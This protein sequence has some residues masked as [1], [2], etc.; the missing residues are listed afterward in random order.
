MKGSTLWIVIIFGLP[1]LP[2]AQ[3]DYYS[4]E[5]II[6]F[7]DYLFSQTDYERAI[8][9]YLR[10]VSLSDDQFFRDSMYYRIAAGF[11]YLSKPA[12]ARAYCALI[13]K[14]PAQPGLK[15]AVVCLTAYS[16]YLQGNNDS[17]LSFL[18]AAE[19]LRMEPEWQH[20]LDAIKIA[21]FL[22]EYQWT[23]ATM[24][25]EK[26][27]E[28]PFEKSCND[29]SI[30]ELLEIG[31][32]GKLLQ[33]KNP[34]FAGIASAAIPGSGKVY[35][36]RGWDGL[37][38][39]LII[40]TMLWQAY[41]G[42]SKEGYRSARGITFGTLGLTFYAGNIYGSVNAARRYNQSRESAIAQRARCVFT[43]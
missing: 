20:R 42:F 41:E 23:E 9:E 30:H 28:K 12:Q 6:R 33:L 40:G 31:K 7:A 32:Q 13:S 34:A 16:Y 36:H 2:A 18:S 25:A 11:I 39:L 26:T 24:E 4:E 43:W 35:A 5:N 29:S 38:S 10:V 8:S 37:Y 14:K 3:I 19:A 17:L 21:L 1:A 22:K 15:S 27:L